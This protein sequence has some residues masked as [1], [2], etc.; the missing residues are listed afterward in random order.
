MS[1]KDK[2]AILALIE[3]SREDCPIANYIETLDAGE[4]VEPLRVGETTTLHR[5]DSC[6]EPHHVLPTL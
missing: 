4:R 2:G 1:Q 6:A 3:V 5:V